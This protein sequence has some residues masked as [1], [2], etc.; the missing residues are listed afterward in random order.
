[1]FR[2]FFLTLLSISGLVACQQTIDIEKPISEIENPTSGSVVYTNDGLRLVATL[3]DNTGLLQYK[4]TIN[5]IDSLND[6]GADS[7]FSYIYIDGVPSKEK[8]WYLDELFTLS[9]T[10]FNGHY[11]LRLSCIDIEGNE[12]LKDTVVFQI[13]NSID[14]Q[15]PQFSVT[16]P[17]AADTL[18]FG[19]GFS[20]SGSTYD[21]QSLV[22]SDIY[23]GR[24]NGSDTILY[25]EF[26]NPIDNTVDYN[27]IGWYLQV[28]STWTKGAYHL[29]ITS[30]D[31]Y[32]GVSHMIPFHVFY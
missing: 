3:S 20:I 12:S 13:R 29:S 18:N 1:M 2:N 6:V 28:D 9:D 7:T 27:S 23:V 4:W 11:E 24:T 15:P 21:T 5:G 10:I 14:S 16:G 19:Q 17:Q 26:P 30:W 22:Y 25:F 32:S 31:N 8:T